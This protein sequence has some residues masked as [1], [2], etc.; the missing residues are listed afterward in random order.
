MKAKGWGFNMG[1]H[2]NIGMNKFPRQGS[3][4]DKKV[5][6]TFNYSPLNTIS[7]VIVRDDIESPFVTLIKLNDDRY[8]RASECQ[9]SIKEK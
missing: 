1:V 2:E 5:E 6:V 8:C 4:V 7:G 3:L 9:Y